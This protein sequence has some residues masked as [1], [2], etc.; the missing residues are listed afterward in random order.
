MT[1]GDAQGLLATSSGYRST[2]AEV[3]SRFRVVEFVLDQSP[4]RVSP[5][6]DQRPQVH[7]QA[8]GRAL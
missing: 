8:F 5:V 4:Q 3:A 1:G 6:E 7:A 2:S